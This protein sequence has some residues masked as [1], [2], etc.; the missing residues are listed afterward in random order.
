MNAMDYWIIDIASF[1][2]K[3]ISIMLIFDGSTHALSIKY[4]N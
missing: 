2:I 3:E 1:D 4:N